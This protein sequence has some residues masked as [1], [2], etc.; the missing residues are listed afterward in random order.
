MKLHFSIVILASC[1]IVSSCNTRLKQPTKI[2]LEKN[3]PK[4]FK[5]NGVFVTPKFSTEF[6]GLLNT[7][8]DTLGL[9]VNSTYVYFPFGLIKSS[10]NPNLGLLKNFRITNRIIKTDIGN[11]DVQFL[12]H[13]SSK[14]IFFFNTVNGAKQSEILKG[15]VLDSDVQFVNNVRI[16]MSIDDFYK[17]FFDDFPIE[18]E[19]KYNFFVLKSVDEVKHIYSFENG[20]LKSVKFTSY[21]AFDTDYL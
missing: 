3:P 6:G 5:I 4:S 16:G 7:G 12:K 14:L 21:R 17:C 2:Y 20:K 11:I 10:P 1:V 9:M 8:S 18:L 13:G 19:S 15:D